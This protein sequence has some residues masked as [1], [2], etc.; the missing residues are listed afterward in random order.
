MKD[1]SDDPSHHERTLLPQS[2]ISLQNID[3]VPDFEGG[4]NLFSSANY[5]GS[6][7][8]KTINSSFDGGIER[9][10]RGRRPL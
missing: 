10:N 8:L 1:R 5:S 4:S 2:Y 9:R 6:G 7:K 3:E